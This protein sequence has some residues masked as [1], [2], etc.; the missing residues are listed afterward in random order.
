M[1][2]ESHIGNVT[3]PSVVS[4]VTNTGVTVN[5]S[6]DNQQQSLH[7]GPIHVEQ[8]MVSRDRSRDKQDS[9]FS[10]LTSPSQADNVHSK[11]RHTSRARRAAV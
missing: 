5:F 10:Q 6:F 8:D 7:Q 4:T 11:L 1:E 2:G 3:V 9:Y